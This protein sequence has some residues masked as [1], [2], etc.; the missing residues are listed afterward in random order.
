[1]RVFIFKSQ[2]L[3]R[4]MEDDREIMRARIA[5]GSAP[6]HPKRRAGDGRT[7][8]GIYQICLAKECGKYGRSLALNYPNAEDAQL[9]YTEGVIDRATLDA[10]LSA[11]AEGR[12]PPWGTPLGGEIYLHEGNTDTDW[13]RGC[14]ALSPA[15][16]ARLFVCRDQ[17]DEVEIRP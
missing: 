15:D 13:T 7:P 16:M 1:M 11:A 9:A 8:E 12:R 14:V 6:R 3:L 2:R 10:I 5:L 4:L 17:I